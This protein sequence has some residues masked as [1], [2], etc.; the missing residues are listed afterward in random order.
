[1]KLL[2]IWLKK[3]CSWLFSINSEAILTIDKLIFDSLTQM[4]LEKI[5]IFKN[6]YTPIKS[7][8]KLS[9]TLTLKF[10]QS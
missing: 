8:D 6:I 3:L 9:Y 2:P 10:G 4:Y 7:T 5:Y 1:M